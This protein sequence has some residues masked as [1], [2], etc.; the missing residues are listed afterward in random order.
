MEEDEDICRVCRSNGTPEKPLFHPCI[1]TGSIRHVHQ[2]CLIQWLQHSRKEYCE[3]CNY[4][5][6]FKPIYSPD[7]PKRL[8]VKD[9]FFG[10]LTSIGSAVKCWIHYTFVAIA[11]LG[12][13]P[14]TASR[15]Y[16]CVFAGSVS[17]LASLP[18]DM[19][20]TS[21]IGQDIMHGCAIVACTLSAFICLIWLRV[22][23]LNGD[24]PAWLI[25][26]RQDQPDIEENNNPNF[27]EQNV[28]PDDDEA[29]I[30]GDFEDH[31]DEDEFANQNN[32]D[33][34]AEVNWNIADWDH[35]AD[36]PSWERIL[37]LDGSF[38][39]VEHVFWVIALNTLIILVFTFCPYH[40]GHFFLLFVDLH[41]YVIAT[42]FEGVL[43]TLCGYVLVTCAFLTCHVVMQIARFHWP[44]R[45]FGLCY[46]ILKVGLLVLVEIGIF[47]L[48]C[49][50]WLDICTL[51][52][53][54]STLEERRT[55]YLESPGV[56]LFLHW[57]IGMI[58]VF[59]FANFLMLAKEVLRPGALWFLRNLN[60]PDFNPINE[61]IQLSIYKYCRRF[62]MSTTIFGS[63]I[64][65]IAWLPVY[66]LCTIAPSFLPYNASMRTSLIGEFCL[67]IL[68]LQYTIPGL[69]EHG[70]TKTFLK[71]LICEWAERFGRILGIRSYLLSDEEISQNINSLRAEAAGNEENAATNAE[72]LLNGLEQQPYVKPPH[73]PLRIALLLICLGSTFALVSFGLLVVPVFIGRSA[74]KLLL[75]NSPMPQLFGFQIEIHET[76]TFLIGTYFCWNCLRFYWAVATWVPRGWKPIREK[77]KDAS[78]LISKF[79][80][81]AFFLV[82]LLPLLIGVLV[83]LVVAIPMTVG[84]HE[85]PLIVLWHDWA[86]GLLV[87]TLSIA[88]LI[89]GPRTWLKQD[90]ERAYQQGLRNIPL[91]NF[92]FGTL[93]PVFKIVLTCLC[94]PYIV[95]RF[96]PH[97]FD[98][99]LSTAQFLKWR[100]YPLLIFG[101]NTIAFCWYEVKQFNHLCDHIKNE[102]YLIGKRLQDYN[103]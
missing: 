81:L 56:S 90:I 79:L 93:V 101:V 27:A 14:L 65:I 50:V 103:P 53:F 11:W 12:V 60:D 71:K 102:R 1:C 13:V 92:I 7:M 46:I 75:E 80:I 35:D 22:Q 24:L 47:P 3:L 48:L 10:L 19:L 2:D 44:G 25:P 69:L 70:N 36:E 63:T 5:Y 21:S 99:S 42:K 9:L 68:V 18:R 83:D 98:C 32:I 61:M 15:I 66:L 23:V 62:M 91:C 52:V 67:Q 57:V 8:P 89:V 94:V 29:V 45:V 86:L 95:G 30:P 85:T 26:R 37:G 34:D 96:V 78:K 51:K 43:T 58:F 17:A 77:I 87:E 55:T 84:L 59:Y 76:Y 97:F 74:L 38:L 40:L 6:T 49:G 28:P 16:N 39:F 72:N 41:S 31:H 4:K 82:F 64:V 54:D 88:T 100:T 33:D 73:F 20:S